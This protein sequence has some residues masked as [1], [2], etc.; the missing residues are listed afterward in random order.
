MKL[1]AILG[2][3]LSLFFS[4]T[5]FAQASGSLR[6]RVT[7]ASQLN[8]QGAKLTLT[9]LAT[10]ASQTAVSDSN[11]AYHF[12]NVTPGWYE[13]TVR[14]ESFQ[15]FTQRRLSISGETTFDL[16]LEP[17]A[18][19]EEI[20]VLGSSELSTATKLDVAVRDTPITGGAISRTLIEQQGGVTLANVLRNVSGAHARVDYGLYQSLTFRGFSG[21]RDNV[22]LIDGIRNEG[23]R[24][25]T[26]L[27]HIERVE[28]LKGPASVLYGAEAFSGAVNLIRKRPSAEPHYEG[29]FS[30]G[31]FQE[32]RGSFGATGGITDNLLYRFDVGGIAAN[33]WRDTKPRLFNISPSLYWYP[34]SRAQ[35]TLHYT[36]TRDRFAT[37]GGLPTVNG[38][39]VNVPLDRRYNTPNDFALSRDHNLQFTFNYQVG[40][41]S[42]VRNLTSI[43][44]YDDEYFSAE[45]YTPNGTSL[46]R[47]SLYF[48]H[49]R[50]PILNQ[51]QYTTTQQWGVKHRIVTGW[52]YQYF[53]NVTDRA[54][55]TTITPIDIFRPNETEPVRD[56]LPTARFIHF[57]QNINALYAQDHLELTPRLKALLGLRYDIF[58]RRSRTDPVTNGVS[59]LGTVVN[60][61]LESLTGRAGLVYSVARGFS[62]YGSFGTAFRPNLQV[63]LDGRVLEPESGRQF[64]VGQRLEAFSGRL[65]W[66]AALY[67]YVKRNVTFARPGPFFDQAGKVRSRGFE[68]DVELR[69]ATTLIVTANYALT[70]AKFEDFFVGTTNLT[71]LRPQYI[72]R[73]T[74]NLWATKWF[75]ER[76][77]LAVGANYVG[78]M[79][80]DNAN[81][82]RLGNY[83]LADAAVF[84]RLKQAEFAVNLNNLFNRRRYFNTAIYDF[85]LYPGAPFN[86]LFTVRWKR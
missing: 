32:Y 3:G 59:T 62:V 81:Q 2:L 82:V 54:N 45:L 23:N 13:L 25:N 4:M 20:V 75:K 41:R 84:L 18:V 71:G 14:S 86:A 83:V 30:V 52:E 37:D 34:T 22:L 76:V 72:P 46:Q 38:A 24:V 33:Q 1:R 19:R 69:P 43:R 77:G 73:H 70:D 27:S 8:V 9:N 63:P 67:H 49:E 26:Q 39:I 55:F 12:T 7:D 42:E 35:F 36:F 53:P 5:V 51:L 74:A 60:R 17:G 85:Q 50:N 15:I 78:I 65:A 57:R 16:R 47:G 64:E 66:N 68:T 48:L 28:V 29:S 80:S 11:G 40:E 58:R 6:G 21:D 61:D 44:R 10:N 56:R 79:F 31:S